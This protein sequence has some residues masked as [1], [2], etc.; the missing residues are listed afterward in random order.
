MAAVI[1]I[2]PL[3]YF[4]LAWFVV[5]W[6]GYNYL[7]DHSKLRERSVSAAM[8]RYRT[9]WMRAMLQ[10]DLR[11]IDTTIMGNILNGTGFFASTTILVAGGL[12]AALGASETAVNVLRDLPF[13]ASTSRALFE[14]KVLVMLTIFIIAFFKM[15]WA[16][17]LYNNCSVMIGAAPPPPVAEP[18]AS[19]FAERAGQVLGFAAQHANRG[20][21]AYFFA[22]AILAWF[23]HP[24]AF[25]AAS[26]WI[27][28]VLY[29]REFRSR[30]LR[31]IGTQGAQLRQ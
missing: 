3:N 24:Y 14:L 12:V 10:R 26:A 23:V 2:D 1:D 21:R 31:A 16:F 20:L 29:R 7:A 22:L 11:V 25:M 30:T 18:V 15:S 9:D 5:C 13:V 28:V 27:V 17:R 4:A 8:D 6:L 19:E